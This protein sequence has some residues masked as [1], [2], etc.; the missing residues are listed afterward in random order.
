MAGIRLMQLTL[1]ELFIPAVL[2]FVFARR[3]QSFAAQN[4]K[5]TVSLR[6]LLVD[7]LKK[8][9][10]ARKVILLCVYLYI[11]YGGSGFIVWRPVDS[12]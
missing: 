2:V 5:E 8:E 6:P 3:K 4:K 12:F 9:T 1:L 11:Y 7:G 10:T